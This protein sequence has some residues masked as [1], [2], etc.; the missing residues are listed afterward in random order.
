MPESQKDS[1]KFQNKAPQKFN[2]PLAERIKSIPEMFGIRVN[3]EPEY[4][5]LGRDGDK[6][7]RIYQPQV[8]ALT[9]IDN[10][11]AEAH[12]RAFTRLAA[13]IFGSNRENQTLAMTS[14]VF[15]MQQDQG[16]TMAFV[17]PKE[18]RFETSPTPIDHGVELVQTAPQIWASFR[19]SGSPDLRTMGEKARELQMWVAAQSGYRPV[20]LPRFAQYDPPFSIPFLKRNEV[21]IQ[22]QGIH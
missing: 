9:T 7:I 8:Q 12:G 4:E 2:I 6:E 15:R 19:F 22:V 17:L 5:V 13:Y 18:T 11:S 1:P 21:Q 3:E 14:P 20:S 16:W 10:S